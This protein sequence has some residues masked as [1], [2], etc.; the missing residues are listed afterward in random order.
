MGFPPTEKLASLLCVRQFLHVVAFAQRIDPGKFLFREVLLANYNPERQIV[1]MN[2][3]RTMSGA[4][5]VE[6]TAIRP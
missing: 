1:V 2:E 5:R 3:E 4:S 6:Y